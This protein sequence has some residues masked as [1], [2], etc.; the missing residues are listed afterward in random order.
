[1]KK[2]LHTLVTIIATPELLI[3]PEVSHM[4]GSLDGK[5]WDQPDAVYAVQRYAPEL[6]HLKDL[7]L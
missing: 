3:G 1:M 7:L 5:L 6:P 4:T 2:S